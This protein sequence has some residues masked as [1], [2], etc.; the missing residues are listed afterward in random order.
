MG[1]VWILLQSGAL[2]STNGSSG[3]VLTGAEKKNGGTPERALARQIKRPQTKRQQPSEL[4]SQR[5][6]QQLP[7]APRCPQFTMRGPAW[8]A[9]MVPSY[10]RCRR[11]A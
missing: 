9:H 6:R 3:L 8:H 1:L 5:A 7:V 4:A 2:T 10:R 11:A